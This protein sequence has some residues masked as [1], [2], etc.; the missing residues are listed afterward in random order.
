MLV[1]ASPSSE[2]RLA[3]RRTLT[4]VLILLGL[5]ALGVLVWEMG[6]ATMWAQL[7]AIG[8][9]FP[10]IVAVEGLSNI[11]SNFGWY[12]AFPP[13]KRPHY[14]RLLS[15][16]MAS[17]GVGS[18]LPTGQAG[19]VA[20]WN[21]LRADAE[22]TDVVSSLLV[23]NYLHV[24]TTFV[25]VLVGPLLALVFGGGGGGGGGFED[26]IV[27]LTLAIG[28]AGTVLMGALLTLFSR[29]L[30][31]RTL[32]GLGRFAWLRLNESA[33]LKA[34][35]IDADLHDATRRRGDLLRCFAGLFFGRVFSVLEILLILHALGTSDSLVVASMVFSVTAV[36]NYLLMVLPVRE[37]FLEASTL[38]VFVMLGMKGA[39]GLSLEIARRLRKVVY[40]AFGIVWMMRLNRRRPSPGDPA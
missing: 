23:Y 27:W 4:L 29:R 36:V 5:I 12:Y 3:A 34:G 9:M 31:E 13:E 19:E 11:T 28:A 17:L 14:G 22:S 20:K 30:V 6:P 10:A 16:Q 26:R 8:P 38:G 32:R 2:S 18:M 21:L 24:V 33:Y 40:Q 37:G 1:F 25:A 15:V 7:V 35:Q 39:D